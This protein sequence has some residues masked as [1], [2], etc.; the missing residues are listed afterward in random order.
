MNNIEIPP[1]LNAWAMQITHACLS[2]YNPE[3]L[4]IDTYNRTWTQMKF[5]PVLRPTTDADKKWISVTTWRRTKSLPNP[6]VTPTTQ[7]WS[8]AQQT[9]CS[10]VPGFNLPPH[11]RQGP[12]PIIRTTKTTM[13][14]TI[15]APQDNRSTNRKPP[16]PN[17]VTEDL[18]SYKTDS[19]AP[20]V[21]TIPRTRPAPN[22]WSLPT[23]ELIGLLSNGNWLVLSIQLKF[24]KRQAPARR[25]DS[26]AP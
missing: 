23:M 21:T 13:K 6:V 19:Q 26:S 10:L 16:N 18:W 7:D 25:S 17:H 5:Q 22:P 9:E 24:G 2:H 15:A 20:L 3:S 11:A 1:I 8:G 12:S 14:K 4:T